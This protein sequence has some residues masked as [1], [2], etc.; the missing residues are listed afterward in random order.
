MAQ[1]IGFAVNRE[2]LFC[3]LYWIGTEG[4]LFQTDMMDLFLKRNK[5]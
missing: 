1:L 2:V 5:G 4:I 3:S